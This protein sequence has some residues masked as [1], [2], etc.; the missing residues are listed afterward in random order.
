MNKVKNDDYVMQISTWRNKS[1]RAM[2]DKAMEEF[3]PAFA[4]F[5]G[6]HSLISFLPQT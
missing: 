4:G 2:I 6:S 5:G 1:Y 3:I